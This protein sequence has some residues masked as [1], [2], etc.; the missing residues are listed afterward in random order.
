[1]DGNDNVPQFIGVPYV[2]SIPE[3]ISANRS[4]VIT[5]NA[6][7]LDAGSAGQVQYQLARG[8]DAF[9]EIDENTVSN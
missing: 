6:T 4:L 2:F 7:D 5:V 1:M 3:S 8:E 9:F